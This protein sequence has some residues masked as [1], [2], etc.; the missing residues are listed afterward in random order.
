GA[1]YF[2]AKPDPLP[3]Q[4]PAHRFSL[5]HIRKTRRWTR[6]FAV[7][8]DPPIR[9]KSKPGHGRRPCNP[10]PEAGRCFRSEHKPPSPRYPRFHGTENLVVSFFVLLPLGL[11]CRWVVLPRGVIKKNHPQQVMDGRKSDLAAASCWFGKAQSEARPAGIDPPASEP[12]G[13]QACNT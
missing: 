7:V 5:R 8:P 4:P 2:A 11:G 9:P 12:V 10:L 6:L 3:L 13:Y 1:R